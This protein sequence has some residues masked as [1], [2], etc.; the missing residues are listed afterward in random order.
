MKRKKDRFYELL[1]DYFKTYLP[2]AKGLAD[3]TIVSYKTTF[4][5]LM[6]YLYTFENISAED[7]SFSV[8]STECI[9]GFLE[10]LET[11]RNCSTSTRNQRLSAIASPCPTL[12]RLP[13]RPCSLTSSPS[14][15]VRS[16]HGSTASKAL[17]TPVSVT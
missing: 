4:R 1:E 11:E 17:C 16:M 12:S 5:L 8:L 6:E 13:A 9:Q 7:I 14:W 15:S 2:V 3:T 10:W